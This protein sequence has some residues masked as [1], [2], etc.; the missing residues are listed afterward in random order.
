MLTPR[1]G[2]D[3]LRHQE[4]PHGLTGIRYIGVTRTAGRMLM[5]AMAFNL[6]RRA[7]L[8]PA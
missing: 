4:A 5:V 6:R 7:L 8:Q 2:G 1:R 3:H